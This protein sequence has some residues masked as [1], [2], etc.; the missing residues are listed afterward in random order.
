MLRSA[1]HGTPQ[2]LKRCSEEGDGQTLAKKKKIDLIFKDVLEASLEASKSQDIPSDGALPLKK[3][4]AQHDSHCF[5]HPATIGGEL[6]RTWECKV[7]VL[8]LSFESSGED[9]EARPLKVE[10]S[11]EDHTQTGEGPSTSFCPNCVKL[12]KRIRELEAEVLRLRGGEQM[13]TPAPPH[14]EQAPIEDFQGRFRKKMEPCG[15]GYLMQFF[16]YVKGIWSTFICTFSLHQE[17]IVIFSKVMFV[18]LKQEL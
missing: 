13:E 7:P 17:H 4:R 11:E 8:G 6:C 1:L 16:C 14:P 9:F 3:T 10:E 12:K 2:N 15:E 5:S 18:T